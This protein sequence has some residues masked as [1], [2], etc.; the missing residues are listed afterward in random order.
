M[1]GSARLVSLRFGSTRH[2]S[3]WHG[4]GRGGLLLR[5]LV[6]AMCDV[7][8]RGLRNAA[9]ALQ[10]AMAAAKLFFG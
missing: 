5:V 8:R 3:A 6:V 2:G 7:L 10:Q 9:T 4:H 1:F